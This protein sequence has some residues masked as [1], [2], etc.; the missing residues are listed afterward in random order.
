[1]A[2]VSRGRSLELFFIDGRPDGMLTAE[3]FNW[4]GHLLMTPR[5][6]ISEALRRKEASYT[7]IYLLF[8]E[9]DGEPR[10]YIGEAEDV[11]DRIRIHEAK[12]DWWDSAI[13][14][15]S[16]ANTLNKAHVRYLEARLIQEAQAA[17]KINLE[18]QTAPL[19]PRLTEAVKANMETFLE[20]ILMILPA[21]RID[22]LLKDT[23]A[24]PP[25]GRVTFELHS[26]KRGLHATATLVDE[27]FVVHEGSLARKSWEGSGS[28]NSSYGRLHAELVRTGILQDQSD[29][30][31]FS[32]NYAFRSPS[33]AASVV[34]GQPAA[35]TI[36]W[37]VQGQNKTY[38][39]WEAD[40]LA[41]DSAE[42]Q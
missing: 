7:G 13:L 18:N 27:A 32:Q 2:A 15:T 8:G 31:V 28:E 38:K 40:Q 35:G 9:K 10:A 19:P 4:T 1:M 23:R 17:H 42:S 6:Q 34:K 26:P 41:R 22:S 37:K 20:N 25:S 5:T 16:I 24:Q 3:V 21:L 30:R 39:Q 29:H 36:D 33:A 12:M 11:G 14:I